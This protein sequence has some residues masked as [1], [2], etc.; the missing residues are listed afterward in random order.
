MTAYDTTLLPNSLAPVNSH[1]DRCIGVILGCCVGDILGANCEFLSRK[2]LVEKYPDTDGQVYEFLDDFRAFGEYTDDTEMM[3]ALMVSIVE[4]KNID[5]KDI[6]Q[7]YCQFFMAEPRRGYG[8]S[9]SKLL[10]NTAM[11]MYDYRSSGTALYKEGSFA[12]GSVIRVAPIGLV[13]RNHKDD[14]ELLYNASYAAS[15]STHV[16]PEAVDGAF[17]QAKAVAHL[18]QTRVDQL[19]MNQFIQMLSDSC[20]TVALREQINRVQTALKEDWSMN[21][22]IQECVFNQVFGEGFQIKAVDALACV[23]YIFAKYYQQPELCIVKMVSMGGDADTTGAIIG[24]LVGALHGTSYLPLR[25][26]NNIENKAYGRDYLTST[27]EQLSQLSFD[28]QHII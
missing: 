15:M 14:D 16:H 5:T 27:A 1:K 9:V 10:L 24:A 6:S 17:I 11:G 2:Q 28:K 8:P 7:K 25:W 20:R 22:V 4:Q 12:N 13:F 21:K 3:L 23:L 19:D 18:C 26:F